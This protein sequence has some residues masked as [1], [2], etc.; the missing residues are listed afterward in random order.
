VVR[1]IADAAA[2]RRVYGR[3]MSYQTV[4]VLY[5]SKHGQTAKI[6]SRIAAV[7][8]E[9]DLSVTLRRAADIAD[10]SPAAF[11]G[12]VVAASVHAGHHQRE[13]VEYAKQ[14]CTSL[15]DRPSAFLSVSLTAADATEESRMATRE[16]IDDFLDSTGWTTET[17]L[18]VA[19]ALQYREYDFVTRLLMR[20]ITSRHKAYPDTGSAYAAT[21]TTHDHEFT[22][23]GALDRFTVQ[24]A[25]TVTHVG[26][27]QA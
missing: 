18:P 19:G 2:S 14:H 27:A 3:S 11:D 9:R 17:T 7:L 25:D 5:A 10:E 16:L 4:L 24:F 23:W 22:D 13:I 12:C 8:R 26:L 21:D 15:S 6:A 1:E 20:L